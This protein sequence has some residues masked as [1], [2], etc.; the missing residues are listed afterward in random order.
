M[1]IKSTAPLVPTTESVPTT[2]I[3]LGKPLSIR[4]L[5][6]YPGSQEHNELLVV[7]AVKSR[8]TYDAKP[9][10]MHYVFRDVGGKLL[11]P[12]ASEAG[13]RIVYYSPSMLDSALDVELRFAYDDFDFDNAKKWLDV[14]AQA[15]SLP[16][17]AVATTLGGAG[18]AA[19]GKSI[20]YFAQNAVRVVLGALD[21]LVDSDNDWSSTGT[22]SLSFGSSGVQESQSG[23]VLFYGD[24]ENAQIL[25]PVGGD[26]NDQQFLARSQAYKVDSATGR[27]VYA[28]NPDEVV[29]ED[30]PYVLTYVNGAQEDELNGWKSAA[31]SAALTAKFLNVEEGAANDIGALLEGYNDMRMATLYAERTQAL[32]KV[33]LSSE[34]RAKLERER[35]AYLKYIQ[36][37]DVKELVTKE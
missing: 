24:G 3:G 5:S 27:V 6:M 10:A 19:A 29:L 37:N 22:F 23:Y 32:K 35:D 8:T 31:V 25:A 11:D 9:R 26:L 15:A 16:V 13:S 4:I 30:E 21:R 33:G 20:L 28:D 18:G 17:F 36:N 34:E 7:S 14:A 1:S 2:P 12:K